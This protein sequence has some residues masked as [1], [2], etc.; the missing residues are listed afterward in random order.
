MNRI[1]LALFLYVFCI[2]AYAVKETSSISETSIPPEK[3]IQK[4]TWNSE[5]YT[6]IKCVYRKNKNFDATSS[7]E[8]ARADNT[9]N[10]YAIVNGHWY[11]GAILSNMFYTKSSYQEIKETCINTL[12]N[13]GVNYSDLMPYASD[14]TLSYYYSFWNEGSNI[15]S[16]E[17]GKTRLDRMVVFGDSLSDTINVYNGSYGTVPNSNTWFLGHFSNGLVWHEYLSKK[18]IKVP[19]YT[20]ATGNAESGS[21]LIFSGFSQQLDSFEYY[22]KKS[23]GYDIGQTLFLA[24]FGGNDFITGGKSP[25]D[26]INNYKSSLVRLKNLGAKQVAIFTLPDFSTIPSV[27]NWSHA[28][29][30]RLKNKSI[31]FNVKLSSLIYF[32][33]STY[34]EVKWIMLNLNAAFDTIIKNSVSFN[35]VNAKD[36]CLNL[37]DTSIDYIAGASPR[38]LCK[39]SNGAFIFWDN[40]HP[41]T[42]MHEDISDILADEI[43]FSL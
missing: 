26:I 13:K 10:N 21:N 14:Y 30:D 41:T 15:P 18:H 22:M 12:N 32:L 9:A 19:S 35:Y 29:K 40:M 33:K 31:E 42:K 2:S 36:T 4:N 3:S 34:P 37:K 38:D 39:N 27:E 20:W 11:S 25:D 28:K 24:L 1:P 6:Y 17:V 5:T 7:W 8:W 43:K 16:I 23:N